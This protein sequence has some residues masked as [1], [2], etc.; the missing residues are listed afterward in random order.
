MAQEILNAKI[1]EGVDGI[2]QYLNKTESGEW[3]LRKV[4][5]FIKSEEFA[6][7]GFDAKQ[8][9]Q[10]MFDPS[11][12]IS[13]GVLKKEV[14]L[15]VDLL[16]EGFDVENLFPEFADFI[17]GKFETDVF[18]LSSDELHILFGAVEKMKKGVKTEAVEGFKTDI[19]LLYSQNV[20]L[21]DNKYL[22]TL[23]SNIKNT[24]YDALE[25]EMK[26][27]V[28]E[29]FNRCTVKTVTSENNRILSSHEWFG[30]NVVSDFRLFNSAYFGSKDLAIMVDSPTKKL[31]YER[32]VDYANLQTE[33]MKTLAERADRYHT[34]PNRY[35][36][37][38]NPI[39]VYNL[40]VEEKINLKMK[41][42]SATDFRAGSGSKN[43]LKEPR[44]YRKSVAPQ[45][46]KLFEQ[47]IAEELK[48]LQTS[49]TVSQAMGCLSPYMVTQKNKGDAY[50]I[51]KKYGA[52]QLSEKSYNAI[53]KWIVD[54]VHLD[55]IALK[56]VLEIIPAFEPEKEHQEEFLE[57]E[58]FGR[59]GFN[60][61]TFENVA[62]PGYERQVFVGEQACSGKKQNY[63]VVDDKG[64]EQLTL[65]I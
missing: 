49:A 64:L 40:A 12:K 5:K 63:K 29:L 62:E 2:N 13:S 14:M 15:Y 51:V 58:D 42:F 43:Y 6:S 26:Q 27:F 31:A 3:N 10:T 50:A 18:E 7:R 23:I 56:N 46:Q 55:Q 19:P 1:A 4:K 25:T 47:M 32:L 38:T 52:E 28:K 48:A 39:A 16:N 44:E 61:N 20:D 9:L 36:S 53:G 34:T 24:P 45:M 35:L 57:K 41:D 21:L 59:V 37:R 22:S 54:L 8:K 11:N 65:D 33:F 17:S 60:E 30:K